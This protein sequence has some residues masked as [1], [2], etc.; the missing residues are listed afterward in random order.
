MIGRWTF[1]YS[2]IPHAGGWREA[3]TEAHAFARPLRSVRTSRG[4]GR[5]P[6]EGSLLTVDASELVVS[7]VKLAEDDDSVVARVYNIADE[8]IVAGVALN[9]AHTSVRAVDLNEENATNVDAERL[10]LRPNEIVTL[11]FP[12][13]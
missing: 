7:T 4:S 10:M 13:P 2:L 12:Q 8:P 6:R 5:L 9:E 1:E 11:K 3:F